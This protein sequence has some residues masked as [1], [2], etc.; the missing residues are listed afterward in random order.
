MRIPLPDDRIRVDGAVDVEV[1]DGGVRPHRLALAHAHEF[2]VE[3]AFVEAMTSGVRLVFETDADEIT[4]TSTPMRL[5]LG[6]QMRPATF[7]LL[8]AG[9]RVDS[10]VADFGHVAEVD[11]ADGSTELTIGGPGDVV[12][13]ADADDV[14]TVTIWLPQAAGA[15]VHSVGVPEGAI[16]RASAVDTRP[17]WVHHGSSIS[18]CMEAEGPSRTWPAIA[19][20]RTGHHLT[21]LGLAGQCHV[22]QFAAR[23]IRDLPADRISLKFGIN[24][25]N[26]DTMRART[27]ASAVHGFLDTVRDGHPLT[28]LLVISPIICPVAESAPGPTVLGEDG[29][30]SVADPDAPLALGRLSVGAIRA[31]LVEIVDRRRAV[32]DDALHY[33]DGRELFGPAD[34][35]DLPDG[36]HPNGAGYE[37]MGERF[38][39][40][41]FLTAG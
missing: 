21:N 13:R 18:H 5:S 30:I 6:G 35:A 34:V 33:L 29:Q 32:G 10:A 16:V 20:T 19:A 37:R 14:R 15:E 28:P 9:R 2:P 36:L 23:T 41:P 39:E 25:V 40:H 1:V 38:A 31:L 24:V 26:G 3:T 27:F 22:D 8:V 4:V 12:L 11:L 17:R 7:E